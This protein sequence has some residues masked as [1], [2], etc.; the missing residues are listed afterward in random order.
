MRRLG[1][2]YRIFMLT[3]H[4]ATKSLSKECGTY[5]FNTDTFPIIFWVNFWIKWKS[6]HKQRQYGRVLFKLNMSWRNTV[7]EWMS[8]KDEFME[9]VGRLIRANI[10]PATLVDDHKLQI[11]LETLGKINVSRAPQGN[12]FLYRA[13]AKETMM[14]DLNQQ[15]GK[16]IRELEE[17]T[18]FNLGNYH[19][20]NIINS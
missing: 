8:N 4:L 19:K 6:S 18:G 13:N 9:L 16:L 11:T 1:N 20:L 2:G 5:V 14:W 12:N 10:I 15:N 17:K 3:E 7:T